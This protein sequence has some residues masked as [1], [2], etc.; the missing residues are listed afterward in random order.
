MFGGRY[1]LEDVLGTFGNILGYDRTNRIFCLSV[2]VGMAQSYWHP[3]LGWT[4]QEWAP[5]KMS[6]QRLK[7]VMLP[8]LFAE[9][10]YGKRIYVVIS[11]PGWYFHLKRRGFSICFQM[12]SPSGVPLRQLRISRQP[13]L[14]TREAISY[15]IPIDIPTK[16]HHFP[17]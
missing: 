2:V 7:L 15:N 17:S 16:N 12:W 14:L 8:V 9:Q 4:C 11:M 3:F 1:Y 13:C 5:F 10:S 6:W